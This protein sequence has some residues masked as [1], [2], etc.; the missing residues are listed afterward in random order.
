MLPFV[1]V[2]LLA[3]EVVDLHWGEHLGEQLRR[4]V[5]HFD[6]EVGSAGSAVGLLGGGGRSG[7][8]AAVEGEF[9]LGG[10]A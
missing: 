9:E 2:V 3:A 10:D 5:E 1:V 7:G 6:L 4:G 8:V